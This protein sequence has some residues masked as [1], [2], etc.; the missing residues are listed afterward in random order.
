MF[1]NYLGRLDY[2][3]NDKQRIFFNIGEYGTNN[4]I[5]D[6]FH[7]LATGGVTQGPKQIINFNDTKGMLNNNM[8]EL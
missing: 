4:R 3:L 5:A 7:T 6:L 2:I 1:T 8:Y